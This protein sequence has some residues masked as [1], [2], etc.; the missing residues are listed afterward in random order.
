MYI[1]LLVDSGKNAGQDGWST[2]VH[3][4]AVSAP[5]SLANVGAVLRCQNTRAE[6]IEIQRHEAT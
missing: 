5:L 6:K 3:W 1:G 2:A 4:Q